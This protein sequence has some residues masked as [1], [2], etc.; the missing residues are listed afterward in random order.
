[1]IRAAPAAARCCCTIAAIST[2][3]AWGGGAALDT[4]GTN[5]DDLGQAS[6]ELFQTHPDHAIARNA[7]RPG[8][9]D[10][11][12]AQVGH[13][14]SFEHADQLKCGLDRVEAVE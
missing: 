5:V 8:L 11:A 1:L 12:V 3:V 10:D 7:T 13:A 9:P 14:R 2:F 4:A 6:A